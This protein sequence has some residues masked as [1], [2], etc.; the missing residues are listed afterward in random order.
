MVHGDIK[1]GNVVMFTKSSDS[2]D[3][4]AKIIDFGYSCFG[5]EDDDMVRITGTPLWCAP[6]NIGGDVSILDAKKMDMYSFALVCCWILFFDTV[7]LNNEI[8]DRMEE[9]SIKEKPRKKMYRFIQRLKNAEKPEKL[10]SE[11]ISQSAFLLKQN[12]TPLQKLLTQALCKNPSGRLY[13][14]SEFISVLTS[15]QGS[16][17]ED[18]SRLLSRLSC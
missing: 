15:L 13:D 3:A 16:K 10:I 18:A 11:V 17:Y 8:G 6:E 2:C 1:P 14:W 7:S 9:L 5:M 12:T 4:V